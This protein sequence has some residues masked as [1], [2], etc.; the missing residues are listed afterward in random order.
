MA[1]SCVPASPFETPRRPFTL[2][3]MEAILRRRRTLGVAEMMNFPAVIAGDERE[4]AKRGRW[5]RTPTAT[6][7]GVTGRGLDAY[8][9]AGISTDHEAFEAA[10]RRSRSAGAAAAC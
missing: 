9:P 4:L 7:P 1:P 8:L 3:D 10:R 2:G 5:R 6:R